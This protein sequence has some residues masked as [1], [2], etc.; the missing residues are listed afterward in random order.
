MAFAL[1]VLY[2]AC[3]Y[4]Q[5]GEIVPS[6]APYRLTF[7][8]GMAGLVLLVGPGALTGVGAVDPA[9][10]LV[11][12]GADLA[13]AYGSLL[14]RRAPLPSSALLATL[15][16]GAASGEVR[17]DIHLPTLADRICQS[18]LHVGLDVI[19]HKAAADRV[20]GVLCQ[21]LLHGLASRPPSDAELDRPPTMTLHHPCIMVYMERTTIV[22]PR[23]TQ[24]P[25][26]S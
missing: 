15:R 6:L 3:S 18:M 8:I 17:A 16:K 22:A 19:R 24:R 23:A 1:F 10:A 25:Q 5:P 12:F 11:L 14:S 7:W 2:L 20:A 9:G 4:V 13:W 21:I 26:P